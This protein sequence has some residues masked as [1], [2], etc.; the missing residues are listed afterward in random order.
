[1]K[2]LIKGFIKSPV[3]MQPSGTNGANPPKLVFLV[4]VFSVQS[5]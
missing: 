4:K 5:G 3:I 2:Q 1:M